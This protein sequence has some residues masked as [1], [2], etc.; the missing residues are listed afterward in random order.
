MIQPRQVSTVIVG[1]WN[2]KI[3]TP[4]WVKKN[5]FALTGNQDLKGLVNF[6]EMDFGFEWEGVTVIPKA[7]VFEVRFEGYSEA[8]ATLVS[9]IVVKVLELLP[10]T[11][12]KA[13]G[14]NIG[15]NLRNGHN[16]P[17]AQSLKGIQTSFREFNLSQLKHSLD[18]GDYQINIITDISSVGLNSNFNFHYSK[19]PLLTGQ[20]IVQHYKE[21]QSILKDGNS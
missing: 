16:S 5:L 6:E 1:S 19:I 10:Q 4:A 9:S 12:I 13:I 3:F 8:K 20:F 11:P 15:Y 2:P 7:N 17:L 21:T 18:K 14:V